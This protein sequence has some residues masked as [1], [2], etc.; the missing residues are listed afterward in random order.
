[1]RVTKQRLARSRAYVLCDILS[2]PTKALAV[3]APED[4]RRTEEPNPI[5]VRHCHVAC[6]E[7]VQNTGSPVRMVTSA[8][9]PEGRK[10][11]K[12]GRKELLTVFI[13]SASHLCGAARPCLPRRHPS[14]AVRLEQAGL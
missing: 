7:H 1:M 5:P 2:C 8:L 12:A 14:A 3:F 9:L 4:C 10:E 11:E 6:G 13:T